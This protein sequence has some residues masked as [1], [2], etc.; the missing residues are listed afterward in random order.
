MNV[1]GT[2]CSSLIWTYDVVSSKI[3]AG[4]IPALMVVQNGFIFCTDG[5]FFKDYN[6]HVTL[7]FEM[8]NLDQ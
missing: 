6:I 7:Y 3:H 8:Y 2:K 1:N 4:A 5:F